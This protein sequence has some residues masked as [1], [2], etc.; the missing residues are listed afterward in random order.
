MAKDG[1]IPNLDEVAT[2]KP[3]PRGK[4]QRQESEVVSPGPEIDVTASEEHKEKWAGAI[5]NQIVKVFVWWM[6]GLLGVYVA[7]SI[8]VYVAYFLGHPDTAKSIQ[9]SNDSL[10]KIAMDTLVPI[11]SF[12]VGYFFGRRTQD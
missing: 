5:A 2:G 6:A 8:A 1:K 11:L 3:R 7:G 9:T 4:R 12:V 10:L